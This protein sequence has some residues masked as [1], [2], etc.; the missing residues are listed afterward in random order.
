MVIGGED[1]ALLLLEPTESRFLT[2]GGGYLGLERLD[3]CVLVRMHEERDRVTT[4]S[5]V[6]GHDDPVLQG[7]KLLARPVGEYVTGLYEYGTGQMTDPTPTSAAQRLHLQAALAI[8]RHNI[9]VY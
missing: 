6:L 2:G 1:A 9:R 5:V 8:L 4:T 7:G 3:R